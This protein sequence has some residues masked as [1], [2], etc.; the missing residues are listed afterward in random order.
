MVIQASNKPLKGVVIKDKLDLGRGYSISIIDENQF[1][2]GRG[3]KKRDEELEF[4]E[5][6]YQWTVFQK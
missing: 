6:I 1:T 5:R 3:L 2:I 4:T